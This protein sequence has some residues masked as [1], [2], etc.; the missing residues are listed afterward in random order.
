M[1][2]VIN[3]HK[4]RLEWIGQWGGI[5]EYQ[6]VIAGEVG[7]E[8]FPNDEYVY[9]YDPN[10]LRRLARSYCDRFIPSKNETF[11]Y[12]RI[13]TKMSDANSFR[14]INRS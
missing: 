6:V 7:Y 8:Y 4:L 12:G 2:A 5:K 11:S 9:A 13:F 14:V 3:G 1:P 10:K